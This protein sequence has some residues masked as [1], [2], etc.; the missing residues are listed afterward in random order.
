[1]YIYTSNTIVEL[2]ARF[3]YW[4]L[5][6]IKQAESI[7]HIEYRDHHWYKL[8]RYSKIVKISLTYFDLMQPDKP[9]K[10]QT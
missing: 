10:L 4:Y 3:R 6:N 5:R 7:D 1:M 9:T 8:D 2:T